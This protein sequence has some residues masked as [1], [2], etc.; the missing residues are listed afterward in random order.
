MFFISQKRYY[1]FLTERTPIPKIDKNVTI[2]I[3]GTPHTAIKRI[4]FIT[5]PSVATV[6]KKAT[7]VNGKTNEVILASNSMLII[8]K[9][10]GFNFPLNI[11]NTTYERTKKTGVKIARY[12]KSVVVLLTL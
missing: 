3:S 10:F 7:N 6:L 8:L 1:Y 5:G 12:D 9:N 4:P 2:E 11:S